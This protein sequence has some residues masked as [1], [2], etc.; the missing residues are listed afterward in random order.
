MRHIEFRTKLASRYPPNII[1]ED[2][3]VFDGRCTTAAP[4]FEGVR[5]DERLVGFVDPETPMKLLNALQLCAQL[6]RRLRVQCS[7][8]AAAMTGMYSVAGS[9]QRIPATDFRCEVT[10]EDTP[11]GVVT[12]WREVDGLALLKHA[13][14][15]TPTITNDKIMPAY[16]HKVGSGSV[17]M[18]DLEGAMS[19]FDCTHAFPAQ[20]V[21][22]APEWNKRLILGQNLYSFV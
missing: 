1:A 15:S 17:C 7:I 18:T 10:P 3:P 11:P 14:V 12:L 6:E 20:V 13:V 9:G 22:N 8:F 19:M 2:I 4:D 21:D 16:T 5:I